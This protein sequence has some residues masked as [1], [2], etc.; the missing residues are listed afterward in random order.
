MRTL[1]VAAV[2]AMGMTGIAIAGE[3]KGPTV[4]TDAQMDLVVAGV[5][6]ND[7]GGQWTL[8]TDLGFAPGAP[9]NGNGVTAAVIRPTGDARP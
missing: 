5:G 3:A 6:F 4:L 2:A 9:D 7:N 8:L 1:I